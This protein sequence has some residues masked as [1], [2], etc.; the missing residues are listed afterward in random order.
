MSN[1]VKPIT[2]DEVVDAKVDAVP[3]E[4]FSAFNELIGRNWNGFAAKVVQA[5]VRAL[6]ISKLGEGVAFRYEWLDV[7]SVYRKAGWNVQYDRPGYNESYAAF[8]VF[9]KT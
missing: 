3:D 8:Y 1:K 9:M 5:E 4:V 2:P 7:E 6:I